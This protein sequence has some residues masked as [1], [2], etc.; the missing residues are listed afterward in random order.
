MTFNTPLAGQSLWLK[1]DHK[2]S[3][4]L[5]V[6]KIKYESHPYY[7]SYY[8]SDLLNLNTYLSF[9]IPASPDF[10]VVFEIPF[11]NLAL[12]EPGY[13]MEMYDY[14]ERTIGNPYIGIEYEN[15]ERNFIS[16]IGF[17][18][19]LVDD[20]KGDAAYQAIFTDPD[21]IEAFTIKRFN[22]YVSGAYNYQS[23]K[24]FTVRPGMGLLY[25]I[26]TVSGFTDPELFLRYYFQLWCETGALTM[27]GGLTGLYSITEGDLDFSERTFHH[28]NTAFF[29]QA[30]NFRPGLFLSV[31]LDSEFTYLKAYTYGFS[32][33]FGFENS[34][35]YSTSFR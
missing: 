4:S 27:A 18:I 9:Y 21:R 34:S 8:N 22:V 3:V 33:T 29:Y 5:E 14:S 20:N 12:K 35:G 26:P 13:G 11:T 15:P 7:G 28:M 16:S 10:G 23:P 19:P 17:R 30:G 24:G 32:L 31:P 6:Y 1:H 25:S 2:P